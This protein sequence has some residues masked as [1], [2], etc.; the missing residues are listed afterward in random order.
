MHKLLIAVGL[1]TSACGSVVA[2]GGPDATAPDAAGGVDAPMTEDA[3]GTPDGCVP[4]TCADAG[5][6]CGVIDDGC[7]QPLACPACGSGEFCGVVADFQC[8]RAPAMKLRNG[9]VQSDGKAA[10]SQTCDLDP[11][12][13]L[14]CTLATH[15]FAT[16]ALPPSDLSLPAGVTIADR[17]VYVYRS[18]SGP[19]LVTAFLQSD[20]KTEWV[21]TCALPSGALACD[22]ATSPYTAVAMP[23]PGLT[24]DAGTHVAGRFGYPYV[25][26]GKLVVRNGYVQSDGARSYSQTCDIAT[27]G[28]LDCDPTTHPFTALAL[29][30]SGVT[31]ASGT[32]IADRY[33]FGYVL[34]NSLVLRSGFIQSDGAQAFSQNCDVAASGQ[35]DCALATHP[36]TTFAMPPTGVTPAAGTTI[37]HRYTFAYVP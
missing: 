17:S 36:F 6:E 11:A 10:Y 13:T 4:R 22:P 37:T 16:F 3:P 26:D 8:D 30:P 31:L 25:A 5:A 1:M 35:L 34:G 14:D 19:R 18:P 33:T 24:L 27:D 29:P 21:Q 32:T 20:G 2:P 28:S 12:G 7:G 9:F 15:P 23:P